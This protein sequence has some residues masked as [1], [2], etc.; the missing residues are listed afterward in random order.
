MHFTAPLITLLTL[1]SAATIAAP[2]SPLS[3]R[4]KATTGADL[5]S[6]ILNE[7]KQMRQ[8]NT[9]LEF[10][11]SLPTSIYDQ[12]LELESRAG[13]G[14]GQPFYPEVAKH[15]QQAYGQLKAGQTPTFPSE[16]ELPSHTAVILDL[17]FARGKTTKPSGTP[18]ASKGTETETP[19]PA[20]LT[21]RKAK[22]TGAQLRATFM[23][24]VAKNNYAPSQVQFY[25]S[26]PQGV[27]D[28]LADLSCRTVKPNGQYDSRV[29]AQQQRAWGQIFRN[30]IPTFY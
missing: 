4:A 6:K 10:L 7:A 17:D 23:G 22:L 28:K 11:S 8:P 30:Q 13:G 1:L 5:K 21:K 2:A 20:M 9:Q 15:V 24:Q 25:N 14:D 26:I 29:A 3:S 27:W 16:E 12:L 18:E 19:V